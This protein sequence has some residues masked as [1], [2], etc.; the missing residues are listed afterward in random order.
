MVKKKQDE[1]DPD[2]TLSG[3][4]ESQGSVVHQMMDLAG[5]DVEEITLP[6]GMKLPKHLFP[7]KVVEKDETEVVA[8]SENGS[9]FVKAIRNFFKDKED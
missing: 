7:K 3:A 8:Q 2:T 4:V 1:Q 5:V 6:E 9:K